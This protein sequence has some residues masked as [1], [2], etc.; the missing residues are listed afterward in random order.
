MA[1]WGWINV[2]DVKENEKG[3]LKKEAKCEK[4]AIFLLGGRVD[5]EIQDLSPKISDGEDVE[6]SIDRL[7][8]D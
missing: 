5:R 2:Y 4:K 7:K 8:S 1:V 6:I 3:I